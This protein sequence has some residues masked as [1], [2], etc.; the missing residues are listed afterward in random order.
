M[1]S[2]DLQDIIIGQIYILNEWQERFL[3]EFDMSQVIAF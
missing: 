2:I 1:Q 3:Q